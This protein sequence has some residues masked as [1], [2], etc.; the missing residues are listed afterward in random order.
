MFLSPVWKVC[1]AALGENRAADF[2]VNR[3]STS[4]VKIKTG[5]CSVRKLEFLVF[6]LGCAI[7]PRVHLLS[8]HTHLQQLVVCQEENRTG[9]GESGRILVL[10]Q[11]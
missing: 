2:Y 7:Y 8:L 1:T 6:S 5:R 10:T 9:F 3:V 4:V 11:T